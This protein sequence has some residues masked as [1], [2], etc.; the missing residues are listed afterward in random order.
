VPL[1]KT[2]L[3]TAVRAAFKKAKDTP[4]PGDPSDPAQASAAQEQILMTLAA[5]LA[6]AMDAFV[7]GG[8]VTQVTVTVRDL[9]SAVIGSGTQTGVG[10]VQ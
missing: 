7:R 5:D 4:P 3:Q 2:T 9:G 1:N 8:D 6:N 10:K